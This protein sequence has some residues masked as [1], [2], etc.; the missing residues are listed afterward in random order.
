MNSGSGDLVALRGC[1]RGV[2]FG[3]GD[4]EEAELGEGVSPSPSTTQD[5]PS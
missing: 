5:S 2:V 4:S 1:L 3:G